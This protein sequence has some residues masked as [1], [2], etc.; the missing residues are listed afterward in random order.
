MGLRLVGTDIGKTKRVLQLELFDGERR[1][2]QLLAAETPR[3]HVKADPR[4]ALGHVAGR[5]LVRPFVL[6]N[7][8]LH[9]DLRGRGLG[10][11]LVARMTDFTSAFEGFLCSDTVF[12]SHTTAAEKAVWKSRRLAGRVHVLDKMAASRQIWPDRAIA[13]EISTD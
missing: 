8:W 7:V 10:A 3:E 13:V 4:R 12:G 1:V 9:E 6:A 11:E 5:A 2:A